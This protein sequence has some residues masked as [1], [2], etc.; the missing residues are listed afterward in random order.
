MID[1]IFTIDYEIYG[2]GEGELRE[3]V[4]EPTQRL[5][6]TFNEFN[7]KFVAFVEAAEL[8]RI[9]EKKTDSAIAAVQEQVRELYMQ[10][11]EIGL[12]LHP[13]WYNG[14]YENG[15]W[16]L[17][18]NEYNLCTLREEKIGHMVE[19]SIGYLRRV[20][21][22]PYY[23]PLSFRAGNWL[24]QP[25]ATAAAI[26]SRNGIKIDSSVFKGGLQREHNLDYRRALKNGYYWSFLNDVNEPDQSGP[27]IEIPVYAEMV[28]FWKMLT[29]KRVGMQGRGGY[30]G[31]SVRQK[32]NRCLDFSRL[33]YPLKLDFCRMTLEELK[34][35]MGRVIRN[36]Q[37]DPQQ[38]RPVVA[39][40]HS[41]DLI[42]LET[43]KSFLSF[44]GLNGVAVATFADVYPRVKD[45]FNQA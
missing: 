30:G 37:Q 33:R 42:D 34:S 23:R 6:A 12:H 25:T 24:F 29:S 43:V 2:N 4:Y 9:E 11:F 28:P 31:R 18:D 13:Q 17:D 26:L 41:K 1:C 8:D 35:M 16:L 44:L 19:R 14:Q 39:I 10:G 20:V 21:D 36:D 22:N 3:L 45:K 27:W 5:M 38:Y 32:L 15:K 7:A 40:G